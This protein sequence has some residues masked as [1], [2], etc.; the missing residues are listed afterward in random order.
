M[1]AGYIRGKSWT[2]KKRG[3]QNRDHY[4]VQN[5]KSARVYVFGQDDVFEDDTTDMEM[6]DFRSRR[7]GTVKNAADTDEQVYFEKQLSKDDTL[8]SVALQYACPVNII[9]GSLIIH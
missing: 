2:S 9:F 6:S 5:V 3:E 7:S 1:S 8:Q 4:Q